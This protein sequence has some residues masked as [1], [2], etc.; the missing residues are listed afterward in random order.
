MSEIVGI[1]EALKAYRLS[2]DCVAHELDAKRREVLTEIADVSWSLVVH[3]LQ[4]VRKELGAEAPEGKA[5]G[6][7]K[8]K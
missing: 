1:F 2:T 6:K 7:G 4:E 3:G 8:P 5:G